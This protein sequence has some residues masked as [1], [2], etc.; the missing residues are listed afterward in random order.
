MLFIAAPNVLRIS[1]GRGASGATD[2]GGSRHTILCWTKPGKRLFASDL[3][4][5]F[6]DDQVVRNFANSAFDDK[7]WTYRNVAQRI[8]A[9]V[10]PLGVRVCNDEE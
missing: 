8:T 5:R 7:D 4:M 2:G 1:V 3:S 6:S 9:Y 10:S